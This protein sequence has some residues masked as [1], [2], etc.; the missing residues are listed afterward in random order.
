MWPAVNGGFSRS[1]TRCSRPGRHTEAD[2]LLCAGARGAVA[3]LHDLHP[4]R[5]IEPVT[6]DPVTD[7]RPAWS[8]DGR[9]LYFSSNRGG[10]MNIWRV[11]IDEASGKLSENPS[12]S[13]P[14]APGSA[15]RSASQQRHETRVRRGREVVESGTSGVRPGTRHGC[16]TTCCRHQGP[17]EKYLPDV[18]PMAT[19]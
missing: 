5:D 6:E 1:M 9:Y 17:S 18:S 19:G 16:G 4:G 14:A 15:T 12:A 8:P 3:H 7:V 11:R 2:R 10:S 13:P